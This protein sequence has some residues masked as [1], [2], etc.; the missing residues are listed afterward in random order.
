[1]SVASPAFAPRTPLAAPPHDELTREPDP[2]AGPFD[3]APVPDRVRELA[4][5]HGDSIRSLLGEWGTS[6]GRRDAFESARSAI[7]HAWTEDITGATH[8]DARLLRW[9]PTK[10]LSQQQI[11]RAHAY[12]TTLLTAYRSLPVD[13]LAFLALL[14]EWADTLPFAAVA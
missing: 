3:D 10:Q 2:C 12:T 1:M 7:A 4:A 11:D 6:D 9:Y 13:N 8:N 5:K 14:D